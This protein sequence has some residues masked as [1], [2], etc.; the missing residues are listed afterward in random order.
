MSFA[1]LSPTTEKGNLGDTSLSTPS[2]RYNGRMSTRTS[3][4]SSISYNAIARS[5]DTSN[6]QTQKYAPRGSVN[7]QMTLT[8][9]NQNR[10]ISSMSQNQQ[11]GLSTSIIDVM[12]L[13]LLRYRSL[14]ATNLAKKKFGPG[15]KIREVDASFKFTPSHDF[16]VQPVAKYF[17]IPLDMAREMLRKNRTTQILD[18]FVKQA[19]SDNV[20]FFIM[21]EWIEEEIDESG[22][23]VKTIRIFNTHSFCRWNPSN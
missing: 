4:S 9:M 1:P 3:R 5:G 7:Q 18:K 10:R 6:H 23:G 2:H 21:K 13:K 15:P 14:A 19:S 22:V 11:K 8:K 12:R 16:I 20:I 17:D